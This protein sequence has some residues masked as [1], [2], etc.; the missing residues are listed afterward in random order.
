MLCDICCELH[1]I[2]EGPC[3]FDAKDYQ[4]YTTQC[5]LSQLLRIDVRATVT[6]AEHTE[7]CRA[8]NV[9]DQLRRWILCLRG[10]NT[11]LTHN[12][13]CEGV[14]AKSQVMQLRSVL[15]N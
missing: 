3:I 8:I 7:R 12:G 9:F 13:V 14:Y 15:S 10:A 2:F 4:K 1:V 11:L 6:H 5:F